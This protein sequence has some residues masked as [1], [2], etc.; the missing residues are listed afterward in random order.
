MDLSTAVAVTVA[1]LRRRP[2]DLLSFYLLETAVPAIAR[3]GLV[4]ALAGAYLHA[5]LTGRI[6]AAVDALAGAD[7]TPPSTEDPEALTRW[8]RDVEPIVE[9]LASPTAL[10]L[11]GGGVLLTA[12]VAI[13]VNAAVSAGQMSAV[14]AR[15]QGD[16]GGTAGVAGSRCHWQ[17]FLG[18]YVAE[19]VLWVGVTA[20]AGGVVG[21]A[22]LVAGPFVGALVGL[23]VLLVAGGVL[24]L[25]RVVFAFAPAAVVVDDVGVFDGVSGAGSFVRTNPVNAAAY[26]VVAAGTLV[27]ISSA[28]SGA[29]YL[30]GSALVA[31]ASAILAAPALDLLKTALYGDHRG[32]VDPVDAPSVGLIEQTTGGIR[33]GWTELA[34]FVRR[35]PVTHLG[36][37]AVGVGAGVVGWTAA[38]PF[39]GVVST[40]IESRLVG[41]VPPVAALTFFGNNWTVAMATAFGGTALVVPAVVSIAL[42]GA[43]LG[44]VAALEVNRQALVAFVAPHGLLEIPAIVIAGAVGVRLGVVAWRT[45]RGRLRQRALADALEHAFWVVV[46]V[47]VLVAVAALIEGFV[48]PYYWRL[49]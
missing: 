42:N 4:L 31:L 48:S 39:A 46:G 23:G 24:V 44:G 13:L 41:H 16:R 30:G 7:L 35:T 2:A 37:V 1:T 8:A 34:G 18:L 17:T 21:V 22:S 14:A 25:V 10:G 11:V 27:A 9:P 26:L 20:L 38:E 5:E 28:A 3:T 6:D 29:V 40:S 12:L 33:R 49:L 19:V 36:V 45:Y 47:G 32:V 15:L 43:I